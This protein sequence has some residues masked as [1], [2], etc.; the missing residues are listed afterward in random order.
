MAGRLLIVAGVLYIVFYGLRFIPVDFPE[1]PW[2]F[3][4]GL[5]GL[6]ILMVV[7]G[8][9]LVGRQF[10]DSGWPWSLWYVGV[11]LAFAGLSIGHPFWSAA[12]L[13]LSVVMVVAHRQWATALLMTVGGS[14][15]L[16]LFLAGLRIGD[17]NSRPIQGAEP[18]IALVAVL[19]MAAGLI[20]I[21]RFVTRAPAHVRPF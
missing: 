20:E 15:W 4:L 17:E 16:Y 3:Q 18:A 7:A 10:I 13:V 9:T 5:H 6:L 14:L 21:G 11:A 12:M 2:F 1:V 8:L 19:L